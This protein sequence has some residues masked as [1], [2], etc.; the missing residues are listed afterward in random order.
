MPGKQIHAVRVLLGLTTPRFST[1]TACTTRMSCLTTYL[2][3]W[4]RFIAHV[5]WM[6]RKCFF[7]ILR[8]T[9]SAIVWKL[10]YFNT[11]L[12]LLVGSRSGISVED[13]LCN[14]WSVITVV[15]WRPCIKRFII[16]S[17]QGW[18]LWFH[19]NLKLLLMG[20]LLAQLIFNR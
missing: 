19:F 13:V 7:Y 6:N 12:C 10:F 5:Q 1:R 3:H 14:L 4:F 2:P 11:L 20:F 18:A 17:N 16:K 9:T 8:N 15:T